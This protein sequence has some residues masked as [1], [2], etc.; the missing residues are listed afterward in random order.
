LQGRVYPLW[1]MAEMMVGPAGASQG[2]VEVV[3]GVDWG[4]NHAAALV[5]AG[6]TGDGNW[7]VLDE[8]VQRGK[9]LDEVIATMR[10]LDTQW[11]VARWWC[12]PSQPGMI[13]SCVRAG[14]D[15][16]PAYNDVQ[17]GVM[18]VARAMSRKGGFLVSTKCRK[19]AAELDGYCW[20]ENTHKDEPVKV[21]DDAAD[22]M[23][24]AIAT[25]IHADTRVARSTRIAGL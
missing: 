14:I 24:Y 13:A 8:W 17:P 7:R 21:D 15:A 4:F 12:D 5:V 25:E 23:R 19:L 16:R 2:V 11:R 9:V 1:N 20:R 6:R 10:A 3:G 18:C 22:A